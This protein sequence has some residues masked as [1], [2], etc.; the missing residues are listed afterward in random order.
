[1]KASNDGEKVVEVQASDLFMEDGL[2]YLWARSKRR[3]CIMPCGHDGPDGILMF[4]TA[5][6]ARRY[7]ESL[8]ECHPT[9][10]VED[11]PIRFV[12]V[13]NLPFFFKK[14]KKSRKVI[15]P[16]VTDLGHQVFQTRAVIEMSRA[17]SAPPVESA[18]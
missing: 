2:Y 1:M 12:D 8:A 14:W 15:F 4:N 13:T 16:R 18:A 9:M 11:W 6:A 5:A 10:R 17:V 3:P 7:L